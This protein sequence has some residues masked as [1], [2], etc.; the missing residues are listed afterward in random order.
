MFQRDEDFDTSYEGLLALAATLGEAKPKATPAH[1][2]AALPTAVY[3]D[4][5]TPESDSR[6]PICLD[7]V[8]PVFTS[9]YV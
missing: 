6:C 5:Q 3:K 2:L 1:V 9:P 4:W 7:D 8:S